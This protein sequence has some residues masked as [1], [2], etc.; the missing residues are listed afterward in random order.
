MPSPTNRFSEPMADLLR[1]RL[2]GRQPLLLGLVILALVEILLARAY[3]RYLQ[4]VA[5][6]IAPDLTAAF[7]FPAALSAVGAGIYA[8][9]AA[10]PAYREVCL[11]GRDL[12]AVGAALCAGVALLGAIL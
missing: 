6:D 7:L 2:R 3:Q 4:I 5:P 8:T 11:F 10:A 9:R 1:G 12:L